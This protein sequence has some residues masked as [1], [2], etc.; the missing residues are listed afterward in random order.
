MAQHATTPPQTGGAVPAREGSGWLVFAAVM[1]FLAAAG[2]SLWGITALVNDDYF[3]I[4]ELLFGDLSAWGWV[5]LALAATQ[6]LTAF[7]ILS[8]KWL[9]AAF[10]I[11]LASVHAIILLA[12]IGAYPLWS[13]I[14]LVV[15]GLIIYG[16][17]VYGFDAD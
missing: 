11:G 15:D 17:A 2:S 5:Y 4:D 3:A 7:L 12:S 6:V 10:G 8:G 1:F 13:S 14:L 16:L 9:G